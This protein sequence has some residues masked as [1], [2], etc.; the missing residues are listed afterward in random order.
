MQTAPNKY[1]L[2]KSFAPVPYPKHKA[3]STKRSSLMFVGDII[4]IV[5]S[6]SPA[7]CLR[8]QHTRTARPRRQVPVCSS[9]NN[10]DDMKKISSVHLKVASCLRPVPQPPRASWTTDSLHVP[11]LLL[12]RLV[13][14]SSDLERKIPKRRFVFVCVCVSQIVSLCISDVT[15]VCVC[16]S[17]LPLLAF[18][19]VPGN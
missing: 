15:K 6:A 8:R 10:D 2:L 7:P 16:V 9:S 17:R 18:D 4:K 11:I 12:P 5:R 13:P 19:V 14:T 1:Y 3:Q